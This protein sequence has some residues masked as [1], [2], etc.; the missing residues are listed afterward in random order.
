VSTAIG[1]WRF[2]SGCIILVQI[3]KE[4]VNMN[5]FYK[6]AVYISCLMVLVLSVAVAQ[7]SKA[8]C[9]EDWCRTLEN[10]LPVFGHR[11]WGVVADSACPAPS[12]EGVE[13]IVAADT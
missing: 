13:T 3:F 10:R 12:A 7:D 5:P 8:P 2:V 9:V 11:N 1:L 4:N 6:R